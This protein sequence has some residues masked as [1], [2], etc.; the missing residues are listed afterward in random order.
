MRF[1]KSEDDAEQ[2]F[3]KRSPKEYVRFG[4]RDDGANEKDEDK[5]APKHYI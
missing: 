4:K 5:R 1:G 3:K 2:E